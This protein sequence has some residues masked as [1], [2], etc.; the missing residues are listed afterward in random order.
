MPEHIAI[1]LEYLAKKLGKKQ[2]QV[3]QDLIEE[4]VSEYKVDEKLEALENI[5]GMFTGMFPEHVDI[6]WIKANSDN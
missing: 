2:S 5:S 3:I 6:Q 1:D 4:K